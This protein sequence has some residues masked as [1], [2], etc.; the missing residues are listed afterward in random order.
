VAEP[1]GESRTRAPEPGVTARRLMQSAPPAPAQPHAPIGAT[2][3]SPVP[4]LPVDELY[5]VAVADLS[6]QSYD[7]AIAGFRVFIAQHPHDARVADA[8][9]Q[10]ADAYAAQHRY[11]EAIP[12]YQALTRQFPDSPLVPTALYREGQARL[13]FGDQG[14]CQVLREMLEHYPQAREAAS[15]REVLSARCP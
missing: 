15:A 4:P 11:A 10:L 7:R 3:P 13:A 1:P 5:S 2:Q 6:R 12:E 9:L 8:R 14:G